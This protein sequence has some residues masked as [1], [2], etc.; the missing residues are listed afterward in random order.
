MLMNKTIW[1]LILSF[2]A[3]G[4]FGFGGGYAIIP[5]VEE[6]AV[7]KMGW[8]TLEVFTEG[9]AFANIL[10]GPVAPKVASLVGYHVAGIIGA[11]VALLALIIP[12]VINIILF[13][14]YY[15]KIKNK[16]FV[17]GLKKA[18][19]PVIV[20][21]I[22]SVIVKM[23]LIAFPTKFSDFRSVWG[24]SSILLAVATFV[25]IKLKVHPAFIIMGA[26]IYGAIF[27]G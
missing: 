9:V 23:T 7:N 26:I 11:S 12:G 15:Y 25:L 3:I 5:L 20:V 1:E 14:K 4:L 10:P 21:L 2:V 16:R 6:D 24:I 17:L 8:V 22:S 27:M 13:N 19:M 18:V